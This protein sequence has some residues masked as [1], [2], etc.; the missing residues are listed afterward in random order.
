MSYEFLG[1]NIY[2]LCSDYGCGSWGV[3]DCIG[4]RCSEYE[5]SIQLN[6]KNVGCSELLA[7]SCFVSEYSFLDEYPDK[8]ILSAR[9]AISNALAS[10]NAPYT[11]DEIKRIFALSEERFDRDIWYVS[12]E[13]W[14][15][16]IAVGFASAKDVFCFPWVNEREIDQVYL[17]ALSILKK[18]SKLILIP[19]SQERSLKKIC[20]HTILFRLN[21]YIYK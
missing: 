13:I 12:G 9:D 6:G 19:S 20:D 2:G 18:H 10:S 16:S 17:S 14:R 7:I 15:I 4:G 1:G 3:S 11:V 5:G 8:K 21:G